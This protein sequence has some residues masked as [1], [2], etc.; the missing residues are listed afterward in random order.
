MLLILRQ[1]GKY[2]EF[3]VEDSNELGKI[4][5]YICETFCWYLEKVFQKLDYGNQ[6][7]F[8]ILPHRVKLRHSQSSWSDFNIRKESTKYNVRERE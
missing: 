2:T 6:V 4:C 7:N 5:I 3:F 8:V 1:K